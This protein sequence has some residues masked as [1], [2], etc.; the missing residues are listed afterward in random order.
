MG[1]DHHE[2]VEAT[3]RASAG[4]INAMPGVGAV[5]FGTKPLHRFTPKSLSGNSKYLPAEP[6][7]LGLEPLKAACPCCPARLSS[8]TL[9]NAS[10]VCAEAT[11]VGPIAAALYNAPH[12][13]VCIATWSAL[14]FHSD[15][16]TGFPFVCLAALGLESRRWTEGVRPRICQTFAASPAEPGEFL[17]ICLDGIAEFSEHEAD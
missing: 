3:A 2:D 15:P 6:G 5:V 11:R 17:L 12:L 10:P 16:S 8:P 7:A 9:R 13:R 14:S 1:H 4:V